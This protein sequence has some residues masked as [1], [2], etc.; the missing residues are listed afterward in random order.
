MFV[1]LFTGILVQKTTRG[2][3]SD[4]QLLGAFK[5]V[6]S[7][8]SIREVGTAHSPASQALLGFVMKQ[9]SLHIKNKN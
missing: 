9:H 6:K 1:R 5:V 7:G 3:Y 2:S 4:E 8:R